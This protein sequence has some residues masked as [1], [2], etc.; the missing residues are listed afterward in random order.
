[1]SCHCAAALAPTAYPMLCDAL[2][3]RRLYGSHGCTLLGM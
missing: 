1:L 2:L 3:L